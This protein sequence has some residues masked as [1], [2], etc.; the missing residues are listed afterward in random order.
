MNFQF[1][2]EKAVGQTVSVWAGK[3]E[4]RSNPDFKTQFSICGK[5]EQHDLDKDCFRIVIGEGS[6]CYFKT[7]DLVGFIEHPE[8]FRD[9]SKFVIEI[10]WD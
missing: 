7:E 9:G 6:Y 4:T 8:T 5:L 10:K 1:L 3:S 2:L